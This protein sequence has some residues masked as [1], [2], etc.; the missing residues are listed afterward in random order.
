MQ[1]IRWHSQASCLFLLFITLSYCNTLTASWHF[2]DMQNIVENEK[3]HLTSLDVDAI[4][5]TFFAHPREEGRTF[6]PVTYLSFALNW[7]IG[8]DNVVGYHIVNILL[9]WGTAV[10]LY[11]TTIQL[12][13]TPALK[14]RPV[15]TNH[16]I[17]LLAT[18]L[19]ALNPIQTQAVTYIVQR[20]AGLSTFFFLAAILCYLLGRRSGQ[21]NKQLFWFPETLVCFLLALGSKE[22]SITLPIVLLMVEW[23]FFRS[24]TLNRLTRRHLLVGA[25][26]LCLAG[27]AVYLLT[28]GNP[29]ASITGYDH[30][31]FTLWQ[32][33]LTESRIMVFYLTLLF[34]PAPSRLSLDHDIAL[35]TSLLQ[36][37]TTAL[38]IAFLFGL[39]VWALW[40]HKSLPLVA[41]AVLFFLLN[42]L[43]EST[44]FP[45]ELIFEHRNYLPSLF[46]FLPLAVGLVDFYRSER[47]RTA[48]FAHHGLAGLAVLLICV[49]AAATYTRNAV[50]KTEQSLWEDSLA[51]AP[52]QSRPYINL[53]VTYQKQGRNDEAFALCEQ[54]LTKNSPTPA[55]DRMRAY[56][57][58]GNIAMDRGAYAEA[59]NYYRQALQANENPSSRYFIHKALL[60]DG[61]IDEAHKELAALIH[62]NPG[63]SELITSMAI[64]FATRQEF[65]QALTMLRSTLDNAEGNRYLHGT[66][67]MCIG[68][69]LSRQ[70]DHKGAEQHFREAFAHAEPLIPLLCV[71]GNHVRQGNKTAAAAQLKELH[72]HFTTET[73]V[74]TV[75]SA[76]RQNI[77]FPLETQE[78]TEFIRFTLAPAP[79][80]DGRTL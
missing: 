65:A 58:M 50:W 21:G 78:F 41:F 24:L 56:N 62:D 51:K 1:Q 72:K 46:L 31:S 38:S 40:K 70:G 27:A 14:Q 3:L 33:L 35:S 11:L 64:V 12:L 76:T 45:L 77:L 74:H 22:N 66:A 52:G 13:Q 32:R 30:R 73:L 4:V 2:D 34:F 71:T 59:T 8:G 39:T 69:I 75:Q 19:W 29:I 9:H 36:P 6:R 28:N 79:A 26:L 80:A 47:L 10:L 63:D 37:P 61:Q 5:Q 48:P 60:A 43:I 49:L 44:I 68:S 54:S 23:I 7:Y 25:G 16:F 55:K 42:H 15:S 57:N 53:A 18:L 20:M 17:A 67:L